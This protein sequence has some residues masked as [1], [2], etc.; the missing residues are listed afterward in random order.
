MDGEAHARLGAVVRHLSVGLVDLAA[1]V[2]V[3]TSAA[4]SEDLSLG[5]LQ[6]LVY[7]EPAWPLAGRRMRRIID[8]VD[9]RPPKLVHVI[10][11]GALP[12]GRKLVERFDAELIFQM[13]SLDDIDAL[14]S[15]GYGS[16]DQ[17]I[18][19]S[20]RIQQRAIDLVESRASVAAPVLIRPGLLAG[21]RPLCFSDPT[22]T[23]TLLCTAR[24]E[25]HTGVDLV[26]EAAARLTARG[27]DIMLFLLGTGVRE[28]ALRKLVQTLGLTARVTFAR[29]LADP[30]TVMNGADIYVQ[31]EIERA[32]W[33]K[34]LQAMAAGLA[35]VT[36]E[37]CA[38][39]AYHDGETAVVCPERT[40]D[41]LATCIEGL[42]K[43]QD[44]ARR[45]GK[46]AQDYIRQHHA[47]STMAERTMEVYRQLLLHRTTFALTP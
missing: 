31:P 33:A 22:R 47:I 45:M 37:G 9:D 16:L 13:T 46:S 30:V 34:P 4:D 17:V 41:V 25:P 32:L 8:L 28:P 43:D 44:R 19:S 18:F 21:T 12:I 39:D 35:V 15:I 42:L 29:P 6:T 3:L 38:S 14:S 1:L 20:E 11:A 40:A 23:S 36:F 7:Q 2:R 5:P 26:I 24:M 10:S 27:H